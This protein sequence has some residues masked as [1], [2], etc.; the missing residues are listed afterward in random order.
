MDLNYILSTDITVEAKTFLMALVGKGAKVEI[1]DAWSEVL[2]SRGVRWIRECNDA[3]YYA[4]IA[5]TI[6]PGDNIALVR[7]DLMRD[8][9]MGCTEDMDEVREWKSQFDTEE[10]SDLT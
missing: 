4:S 8:Y 2:M 9:D 5:E 7:K 10:E 3:A 6:L 1:F